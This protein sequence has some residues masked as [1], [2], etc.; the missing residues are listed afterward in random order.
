MAKT[1]I[2][3]RYV[4]QHEGEWA[5][6]KDY[7]RLSIVSVTTGDDVTAYISRVPVP[8][9]TPVTDVNFWAVLYI[10]RGAG[11]GGTVNWVDIVDK[12]LEF[13]PS[14]HSQSWLTISDKPLSYP[15]RDHTQAISTI[16]GLQ[17]TLTDL[18]DQIDGIGPGGGPEFI[19]GTWGNSAAYET[20]FT[21]IKYSNGFMQLS[22]VITQSVAIASATGNMYYG[23][24]FN[25]QR[26]EYPRAF[27][28]IPCISLST[29]AGSNHAIACV[30]GTVNTTMFPT[31]RVL[32]PEST[33]V[34]S[35][36]V[37]VNVTGWEA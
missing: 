16:N 26:Y 36:K 25:N 7:D 30:Y 2:G 10:S 19:Q 20:P 11:G 22:S 14:A 4:P 8:A 6:T 33:T 24:P 34:Q 21:L 23:T 15:P 17:T 28:D 5:A 32:S 35:I 18:Q 29:N 1:Y 9:G 27:R 31:V 13:P 3:E 37:F 12:P